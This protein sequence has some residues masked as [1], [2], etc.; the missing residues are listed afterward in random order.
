MPRTSGKKHSS[1]QSLN[2]AVKSICDI[3]RRSN[4]AGAL[5]Y[6]PELTWILFLR[7]LD[8]GEARES[9]EA[10]ALGVPFI[11]TLAA[12]FRWR[13]WAAPKSPMRED[14]N[15]SVWKFVHERLLPELKA[16]KGKPNATPKQ[17]VVSEI[18]SGVDRSRIDSEKNFLDVL[19][20]VHEISSENVDQTHVFT[21]SQVYEGLL[22][23][24]GEKGNDGGQFFTP[25]EVI[26][27]MVRGVEPKIGE[28]V[29]DPGCGTGGFLAQSFEYMRNK[30]G[31]KIT[32]PQ[33]EM[34]KHR[35]FYGREKDN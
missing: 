34:L 3:M 22:L 17:K 13:D 32:G 19:D 10:E 11:P 21:L 5:Q 26:R 28:T 8:E 12:P 23:K 16:L 29:Y 2:A 24:M 1:P 20:K 14:K 15:A 31:G 35:T 30:A 7:I 27:A 9:E 25:R 6:V 18:M 4:C 33:L